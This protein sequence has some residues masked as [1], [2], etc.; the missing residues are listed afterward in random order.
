MVNQATKHRFY[1]GL[2]DAPQ[3]LAPTCLLALAGPP[4]GRVVNRFNEFF[5]LGFGDSDGLQGALL[6][7]AVGSQVQL[8]PPTVLIRDVFLEG[9]W[10]PRRAGIVVGT[11]VVDKAYDFGFVV[12][13]DRNPGRHALGF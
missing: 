11:L 5:A 4:I 12:T 1:G 13:E 2:P 9:Q 7:I 6:A 10:L 3:P 8:M